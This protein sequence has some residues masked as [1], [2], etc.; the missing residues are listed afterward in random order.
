MMKLAQINPVVRRAGKTTFHPG[1]D[2]SATSWP[3][4]DH[5]LHLAYR[6]RGALVIDGC[7]YSMGAGDVV[8]V[9]PGESFHVEVEGDKPFSRYYVHFDFF[10]GEAE[11]LLAPVVNNGDT[12]PRHARLMYDTRARVLCAD[13]VLRAISRNNEEASCVI[14]EGNMRSLLGIIS[15]QYKVRQAEEDTAYSK[16][17][18]N[19]LRAEK[20]IRENYR[21]N[22][23]L[24]EIAEVGGFCP[25]YFRRAFKTLTG[26]TPL[27]YLINYRLTEAK[28]LMVETDQSISEIARQV[29]YDDIHYFSYL[30]R[31][32]EGISP[33]EFITRLAIE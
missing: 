18:K 24:S 13:I 9:F 19:I 28:R 2:G 26:S 1:Y 15:E 20:F 23:T 4:P 31:H 33:S 11:R 7:R 10:R 29:G 25:D 8:T 6:G 3:V 30:F 22:I 16:C 27:D 21:R 14:T 17:R 32:R 5:D 12:W